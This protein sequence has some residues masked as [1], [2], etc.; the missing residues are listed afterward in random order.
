MNPSKLTLAVAAILTA[1]GPVLAAESPLTAN[2]GVVSNYLWRGVT[3]TQD[4]AAIQGGIDYAHDSGFS[5]GTWVSN[6]D[7]GT[8][9]PNYELDLYAGYGGK[10]GDFGYNIS[11]TYFAY[12]DGTDANF[13]ELGASGSWSFLTLGLDYTLDGQA[14]EPAPFREGDVYYYA[15]LSFDLPMG[16]SLGGTLG[17]YDFTDFG[18]DADYTHWQVSISKDAGD[19]GTFNL[20]YDQNDGGA[21]EWVAVNDD[22]KIWVGWTKTF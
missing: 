12:P 8:P 11:T 17:H 18:S 19:F 14:S 4:G 7:W 15:S 3:Q 20:S 22:P 13:W 9:D 10:A 6:V 21:T 5:A 2:I 1:T 16:M